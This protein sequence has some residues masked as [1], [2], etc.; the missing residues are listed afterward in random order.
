MTAFKHFCLRLTLLGGLASVG[1]STL[2]SAA[3]ADRMRVS[4]YGP[5]FEGGY[6]ASGEIFS[7]YDHTGAHPDWPFGTLVLLTNPDTGE[8]VTVRINDRSGGAL[9]ISEQAARDLGT[10]DHG[11]APVEVEI[12]EWGE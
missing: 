4:W 11:I 12:I 8:R 9:D 7:R 5:G 6:T 10:Y 3:I 2:A 1:V